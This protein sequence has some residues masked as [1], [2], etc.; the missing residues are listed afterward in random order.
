MNKINIKSLTLENMRTWFESI[1]EKSFH[2]NQVYRWLYVQK[3]KSFEEMTNLSKSLRKKLIELATITSIDVDFTATSKDGTTKIRYKLDDACLVDT[4]RMMAAQM[5]FIIKVTKMQSE[6]IFKA[7]LVDLETGSIKRTITNVYKGK[8]D[9]ASTL[10]TFAKKLTY[11]ALGGKP[12]VTNSIVDSND[13]IKIIISSEPMGASIYIDDK[14]VGKSPAQ[15]KILKGKHKFKAVMQNYENTVYEKEF[16]MD[17]EE[18][19]KL[20]PKYYK[21]HIK[22][23]PS[24]AYVFYDNKI[25][26]TSDLKISIPEKDFNVLA[27]YGKVLKVGKKGYYDK[28][29]KINNIDPKTVSTLNVKLDAVPKHKVIINTKETNVQIKNNNCT[30]KKISEKKFE[31]TGYKGTFCNIGFAKQYFYSKKL[32]I[33][34]KRNDEFILDLKEFNKYKVKINVFPKEAKIIVRTDD[35]SDEFILKSG[36]TSVLPEGFYFYELSYKGYVM[37]T[38]KDPSII[39]NEDKNINHRMIPFYTQAM[40]TYGVTNINSGLNLLYLSVGT[41]IDFFNLI[42]DK[43][44]FTVAG[45]VYHNITDT[46]SYFD[47]NIEVKREFFNNFNAGVMGSI[48]LDG[49]TVV[50]M[51]GL[52]AEYEYS[53]SKNFFAKAKIKA[54]IS[55]FDE[56]RATIGDMMFLIGGISVGWNGF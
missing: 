4:G 26:G 46:S 2:A 22:S 1:G 47:L 11:D 56:D 48:L 6:Y 55:S 7:R 20:N 3:A 40:K 8:L 42:N 33:E 10:L 37:D 29:I 41:G 36:V 9:S 54:G 25:V 19:I 39:V 12:L 45:T 15:A 16:Y 38:K 14:F 35:N 51:G 23:Q 52:V 5:I 27:S 50:P 13:L 24:K 18:K 44:V 31:I 32:K 30:F 28:I 21:L 53:I 49:S 34:F 43:L 17:K